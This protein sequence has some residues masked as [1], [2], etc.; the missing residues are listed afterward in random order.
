M[1][2]AVS[3][4]RVSTADQVSDGVSLNAQRERIRAWCIANGY[5]LAGADVFTDAGISGKRADNRPGLQAALSAA[6]KTHAALVVYSLSRL[7][8]STRDAI[9]IAD[10]LSKAGA[11]LVSLTEAI[12]TTTAAGK[13]IFRV[14]AVFAEF[15]RDIISE[16][17]KAALSYKKR[18]G[19]RVGK[20]PY[21]WCLTA[22]GTKLAPDEN[23]QTTI[24]EIRVM[25]RAGQSYRAIANELTRRGIL[26]KT[27]RA[28][29]TNQSVRSIVIRQPT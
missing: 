4:I 28:R 8:R 20:V 5:D 10:R 29:W 1:K 22:D 9:E 15:E 2:R 16:R 25:R 23:E 24:A 13:M 27:G 26:T 7:A 21:G 11:D 18:N 14:L 19:E 3:Y 17:T 12:D 6:C